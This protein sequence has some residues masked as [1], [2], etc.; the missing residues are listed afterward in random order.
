M[1]K[2]RKNW[3][4]NIHH[5]RQPLQF[6]KV[7]SDDWLH[8]CNISPSCALAFSITTGNIQTHIICIH[9]PH[10]FLHIVLFIL[11][12]ILSVKSVVLHSRWIYHTAHTNTISWSNVATISLIYNSCLLM[13][14][15]IT[16]RI[17]NTNLHTKNKNNYRLNTVFC[18]RLYLVVYKLHKA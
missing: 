12:L 10:I 7:S 8:V 15:N 2:S 13:L 5:L 16:K 9:H 11:Y 18:I 1:R 3:L 17:S 6:T 14:F 4:T